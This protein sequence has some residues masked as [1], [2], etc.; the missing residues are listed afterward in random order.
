M[1]ITTLRIGATVACF[2]TFLAIMGWTFMRSNQPCFAEAA[3]LPFADSASA[4]EGAQ[5]ASAS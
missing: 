3:Q 1:D 4:P 5:E 2:I